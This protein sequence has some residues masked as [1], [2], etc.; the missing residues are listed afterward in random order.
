VAI[1]YV[2]Y[3]TKLALPVFPSFSALVLASQ[4][5]VLA[6]EKEMKNLKMAAFTF[7]GVAFLGSAALAQNPV[8]FSGDQDLP[9]DSDAIHYQTPKAFTPPPANERDWPFTQCTPDGDY[10]SPKI[11]AAPQQNEENEWEPHTN[12]DDQNEI[13]NRQIIDGQLEGDEAS[14]SEPNSVDS[15]DSGDR[16]PASDEVNSGSEDQTGTPDDA[17]VADNDDGGGQ[18]EAS[19][20]DGGSDSGDRGDEADSDGGQSEASAS[21]GGSDSGDRGDEADSGGGQSEASASDGGSDSGDRGDAA[22][23]D[24]GRDSGGGGDDSGSG[25]GDSGGGRDSGGGGDDSGSGDKG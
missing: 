5:L 7:A 12:E 20:S 10:P 11:E 2:N 22:D 14:N 9:S 8:D 15:N 3:C 23:S 21:D 19:A 17:R 1:I 13:I 4:K 16:T 24:G 25:G 6:K 18:S